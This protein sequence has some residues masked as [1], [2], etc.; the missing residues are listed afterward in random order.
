M[1]SV[2]DLVDFWSTRDKLDYEGLVPGDGPYDYRPDVVLP[3]CGDLDDARVV[4]LFLNPGYDDSTEKWFAVHEKHIYASTRQEDR[5]FWLAKGASRYWTTKWAPVAKKFGSTSL[6]EC[7]F[8]NLVPYASPHFKETKGIYD[9]ESVRLARAYA[10]ELASDPTRLVL[11]CRKTRVWDLSGP[12]VVN[13]SGVECR[14][15]HFHK[16][17][18]LVGSYMTPR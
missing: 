14:G 5:T 18:D 11:V 12:N 16:Y 6:D 10:K 3:Y 15:V 8:V 9:V 17:V 1:R 13:F 7:A 4:A 2:R